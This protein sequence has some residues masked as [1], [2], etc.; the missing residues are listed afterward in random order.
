MVVNTPCNAL[1]VMTVSHGSTKRET[2]ED[3]I[4]KEPS[5]FE[6]E[7]TE[8]EL[9]DALRDAHQQQFKP[10]TKFKALSDASYSYC[11]SICR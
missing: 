1:N 6:M 9:W 2:P 7:Q 5:R 8:Q 11:C 4:Q 10:G 3:G